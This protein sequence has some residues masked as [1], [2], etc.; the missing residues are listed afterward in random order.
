M[1]AVA[2]FLLGWTAL[3]VAVTPAVGAML[4]RLQLDTAPV[5]PAER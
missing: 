5:A 2:R 3:S 4:H 1:S